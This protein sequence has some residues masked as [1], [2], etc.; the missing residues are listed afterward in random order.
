MARFAVRVEL[1]ENGT[2]KPNYEELHEVMR[3][4]G[5]NQLIQDVTGKWFKLPTAVYVIEVN[6][7]AEKVASVALANAKKVQPNPTPW[8]IAFEYI[9]ANW[10]LKPV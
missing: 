10:T 6:A 2:Q 7:S 8:V 9:N 3:A 1:H 5:F 4:A